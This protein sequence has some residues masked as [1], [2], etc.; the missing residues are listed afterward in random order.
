MVEEQTGD[1]SRRTLSV[2][3]SGASSAPQDVE[4]EISRTASKSREPS[5]RSKNHKEND[6][7]LSNRLIMPPEQ[8]A[9]LR[10]SLTEFKAV[11][12]ELVRE[13]GSEQGRGFS[14]VL[15]SIY[16]YARLLAFR[17]VFSP[18]LFGRQLTQNELI[19][20]YA[21]LW[22]VLEQA[23]NLIY[24][25]TALCGLLALRA[26]RLPI[27]Q[28]IL[29]EVKFATSSAVALI[30][31]MRGAGRTIFFLSFVLYFG[32]VILLSLEG[33]LLGINFAESN[34]GKVLVAALFGMLGGFANLLMR[35]GEFETIRGRSR[36]FLELTGTTLPISGGIFASVVA[37]LLASKIITVGISEFSIW[38]YIVIGFLAGFS[39]RFT[40]NLLRIAETQFSRSSGASKPS[41]HS[42]T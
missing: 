37:S 17:R 34:W 23:S 6:T 24:A 9:A 28:S 2:I 30:Y 14:A 29:E 26:H 33:G 19:G 10:T 21:N 16:N 40:R 3:E 1:T 35:L 12:L 20:E 5:K 42:R 31:V 22:P 4:L 39:E 27:A 15:S 36:Q 41:A 13:S 8:V 7:T 38:L 25:D 18:S 11:L 32:S